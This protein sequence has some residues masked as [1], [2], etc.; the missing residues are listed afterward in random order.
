MN[1]SIWIT[2]QYYSCHFSQIIP[3]VKYSIL[4]R[5]QDKLFCHLSESESFKNID[6]ICSYHLAG[7][8]LCTDGNDCQRFSN[9]HSTPSDTDIVIGTA[10]R[11]GFRVGCEY[12]L[13]TRNHVHK[14]IK[15]V[16]KLR[17]STKSSHIW[18]LE[19]FSLIV[20][21]VKAKFVQW[22]RSVL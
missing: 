16:T 17:K 15:A 2:L 6:V 14:K 5:Y 4:V 8:Q 19:Y 21:S 10:V 22:V 3:R 12:K 20:L 9:C 13:T 7:Q 1:E 11:W 18:R